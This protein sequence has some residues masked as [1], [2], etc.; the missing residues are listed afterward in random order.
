[1]KL[2]VE[3]CI[4][5]PLKPCVM[6]GFAAQTEP[7]ARVDDDL[8]ARLLAI[9]TDECMNVLIS[10]DSLGMPEV[11]KDRLEEV[12][13]Q[14]FGH[15]AHVSLFCTHTHYAPNAS[16]SSYQ[17]ETVSRISLAMKEMS[18]QEG[19]VSLGFASMPYQ[20]VGTSRITHHEA[21][22]KLSLL[23]FCLNG[24]Q[25]A[26]IVHYNCHPTVLGERH[27][28]MSAEYPG[29]VCRQT[30]KAHPGVAVMFAQGAAGDVST[31]FTRTSQDRKGMEQLGDRLCEKIESLWSRL[32]F[33]PVSCC[34]YRQIRESLEREYTPVDDAL[35]PSG[36]SPREYEEIAQ[37]QKIRAALEKKK[38]LQPDEMFLC[39]MGFGGFRLV[40]APAE[41]FSAYAGALDRNALLV[42]YANGYQPYVTPPG[43]HAITYELF[44]DTLTEK[45]KEKL[46]Q[47]LQ[48]LSAG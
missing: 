32:S 28:A 31:R 48:E 8:H 41:M 3:E 19:N 46:W 2:G 18:L 17:D 23:V 40:F 1:M 45:T 10:A 37:G 43:F 6:A 39:M 47:D 26:A 14:C 4:I 33:Q 44:W 7:T 30:A 16:L 27:D 11:M 35:I 38:D 20:G 36:L 13:K 25:T 22:V 9:G 15:N 24:R 34:T 5:T 42:C 21:S 29:Y 12:A